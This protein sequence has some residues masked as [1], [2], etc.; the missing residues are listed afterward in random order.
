MGSP[1]SEVTKTISSTIFS[2]QVITSHDS[3]QLQ[4]PMTVKPCS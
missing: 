2:L 1:W 3:T 4:V